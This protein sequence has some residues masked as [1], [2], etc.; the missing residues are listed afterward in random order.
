[1]NRTRKISACIALSVLIPLSSLRAV[2]LGEGRSVTD[3][4]IELDIQ[5]QLR[6]DYRLREMG[7]KVR[8]RAGEVTLYGNVP[9]FAVKSELEKAVWQ[10]AGV[11]DLRNRLQLSRVAPGNE[12]RAVGV[13]RAFESDLELRKLRIEPTIRGDRITLRGYVPSW[14][15]RRHAEELAQ[16]V[17]G[18]QRVRNELRVQTN[19]DR[20]FT[21]SGIIESRRLSSEDDSALRGYIHRKAGPMVVVADVDE[22][23]IEAR[24]DSATLVT[25]DGERVSHNILATGLRVQVET[26]QLRDDLFATRIA[27][28]SSN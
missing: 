20:R 12:Q 17:P 27:A 24:L 2:E 11:R 23:L 16:R 4:R 26:R 3:Q 5:D 8:V 7:I 19:R 22:G 15:L 6:A 13:K 18:V 25:L 10:V 9:S 1:M 28:Y 21:S 14:V